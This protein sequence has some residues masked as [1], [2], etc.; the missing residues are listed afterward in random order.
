MCVYWQHPPTERD[1]SPPLPDLGPP[2]GDRCRC[3]EVAALCGSVCLPRSVL[4]N[5]A[6]FRLSECH[7]RCCKRT[8]VWK[9][10]PAAGRSCAGPGVFQGL[11]GRLIFDR[12]VACHCSSRRGRA[13]ETEPCFSCLQ[14]R[15]RRHLF[16]S[17]TPWKCP[18]RGP[19]ASGERIGPAV[20][21]VTSITPIY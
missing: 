9:A 13:Y 16:F 7:D 15:R 8:A 1:G 12:G 14:I 18:L 2:I 3:P 21:K 20:P 11:E 19:G 10:G 6:S 4:R 5:K 17:M